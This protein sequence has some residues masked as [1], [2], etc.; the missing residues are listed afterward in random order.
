[1]RSTSPPK[2]GVAWRIH[3]IDFHVAETDGD[4]LGQD[5]DAAF[6]LQIIGVDDQAMLAALKFIQ[7]LG[8]EKSGLA[9]HLIHHGRFAMVD[10]SYDGNVADVVPAHRVVV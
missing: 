8:A 1:M 10:V 3:Q 6:A 4:V 9:Q 2:I 5:R 7:L